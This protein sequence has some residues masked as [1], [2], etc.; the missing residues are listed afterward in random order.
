MN[1]YDG[2]HRLAA[3]G[4]ELKIA[5]LVAICHLSRRNPRSLRINAGCLAAIF[6]LSLCEP[7]CVDLNDEH[8]R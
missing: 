8:H 6:F 7:A 5:V 4:M 1:C 3:P 2:L